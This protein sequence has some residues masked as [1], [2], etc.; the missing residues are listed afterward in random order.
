MRI[1]FLN[2]QMY[3]VFAFVNVTQVYDFM[4]ADEAVMH[5]HLF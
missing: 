5:V 1:G 3:S 2:K 4:R